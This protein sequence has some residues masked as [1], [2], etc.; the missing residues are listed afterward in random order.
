[1]ATFV[2]H[3]TNKVLSIQSNINIHAFLIYDSNF[4]ASS[5]TQIGSNWEIID[6][7]GAP[8]KYNLLF[9]Y[10][11]GGVYNTN[12]FFSTIGVFYDSV[13]LDTGLDI[14]YTTDVTD[15]GDVGLGF[16]HPV[17]TTVQY[18]SNQFWIPLTQGTNVRLVATPAQ[19][20]TVY[21]TSSLNVYLS[22]VV[23]FNTGPMYSA[24]TKKGYF[25]SNVYQIESY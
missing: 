20:G 17:S 6:G 22:V 9:R 12:L 1:M 14:D 25:G 4:P 5:L 15:H 23:I 21:R 19:T 24:G 8:G 11:P 3:Q 18:E 7:P 16:N 2:Y 10:K 13:G